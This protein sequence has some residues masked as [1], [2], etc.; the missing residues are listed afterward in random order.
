MEKVKLNKENYTTLM[1]GLKLFIDCPA[2]Q[3]QAYKLLAKIIEKFE[4]HNVAELGKVQ[5]DLKPLLVGQASKPRV[6]LIQ[7][8]IS[9]LEKLATPESAL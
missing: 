4:L 9:Q 6:M 5:S 8:Y 7:A 3:K 1:Q 2:T